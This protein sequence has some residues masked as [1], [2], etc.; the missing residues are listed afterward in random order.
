MSRYMFISDC[1]IPFE[2]PKALEFCR[3]VQKEFQIP[4]QNIYN[5]GDEVDLY[6]GSMHKKDPDAPLSPTEELEIAIKKLKQ[7]YRVFPEMKLATSNHG[8]RYLRKAFEAD[9]PSQ[10]LKGYK[11]LLDAPKG[12][13]WKDRWIIDAGKTKICMIHGMGYSGARGHV[14]AAIDSGMNTVIGHLHSQAG[15]N[16]INTESRKIWGFNTGCLIDPDS[17]AFKYGKYNRNKPVLGIGVVLD[18]GISPHFIPYES[19]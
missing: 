2:A 19:F 17:F 15:I 11:E 4:N 10:L 16:Y 13:V 12:W 18:G 14:N 6:H 7:W 1:Q 9:I 3:A 5:V 8:L